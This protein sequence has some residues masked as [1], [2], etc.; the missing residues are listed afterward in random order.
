MSRGYREPSKSDATTSLSSVIASIVQQEESSLAG[1]TSAA[2]R[3]W[4]QANG[5]LEHDHTVGIFLRNT[6]GEPSALIVYIDSNALLHD[7]T[8]KREMYRDRLTN[9]GFDVDEVQFKLS[10]YRKGQRPE[11]IIPEKQ[12]EDIPPLPELTPEELSSIEQQTESLPPHL[13]EAVL[14]AMIS[15]KRRSLVDKGDDT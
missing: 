8:T 1:K 15:F 10:R 9:I 13:K 14:E 2:T 11:G 4:Y 5:T 12:K 6:E 7:F 3:A